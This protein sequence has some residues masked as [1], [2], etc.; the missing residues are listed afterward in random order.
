[1]FVGCGDILRYEGVN[2]GD[3]LSED[4]DEDDGLRTFLKLRRGLSPK[5]ELWLVTFA[6]DF[7]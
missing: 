4:C 5:N 7:C 3:G 6:I 1:M 2:E